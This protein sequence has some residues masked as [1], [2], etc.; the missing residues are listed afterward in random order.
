M[1]RGVYKALDVPVGTIA[2]SSLGEA[3]EPDL[4]LAPAILASGS[5]SVSVTRKAKDVYKADG[6][7]TYI[8][9]RYCYEYSYSQKATL[10][11]TSSGT[12][13][14]GTLTFEK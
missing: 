3:Q 6:T 4:L 11:Y 10:K 2:V 1:A 9:T 13:G 5:Y 7:S 14:S 12:V 8:V